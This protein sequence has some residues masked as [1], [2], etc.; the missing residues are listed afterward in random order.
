MATRH[1][2]K[3]AARCACTTSETQ[4]QPSAHAESVDEDIPEKVNSL[5]NKE[6]DTASRQEAPMAPM[7]QQGM[8][9]FMVSGREDLAP[10]QRRFGVYDEAFEPPG[11]ILH[12]TRPAHMSASYSFA[13]PPSL[14]SAVFHSTNTWGIYHPVAPQHEIDVLQAQN[15]WLRDQVYHLSHHIACLEQMHSQKRGRGET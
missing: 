11:A 10:P 1:L 4:G 7:H 15:Q 12:D 2:K 9:M 6:T 13:P 5:G 8:G 3:E 14:S